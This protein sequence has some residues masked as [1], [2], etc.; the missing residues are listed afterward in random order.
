M[1][2]N[3][4]QL[5]GQEHISMKKTRNLID[6]LLVCGV[7][8]AMTSTLSAQTTGEQVAKVVRVQGA[9]RCQ[10]PGGTWQEL[11]S[12]TVI[13]AGSVIQSG[14]DGGSY[15]DVALGSGVGGLSRSGTADFKKAANIFSHYTVQTRQTVIHLYANTVLGL[16]RLTATDTGAGT[17]T[18]TELDLRKGRILGNVKKPAAGSD[19]RIRC[20]RGAASVHGG[21]FEMTVEE[22]KAVKQG[23]TAP[24]EQVHVTF[25]MA[26]G[27]GSFSLSGTGAVMQDVQAGQSFDS[28]AISAGNPAG[29]TPMPPAQ[30]GALTVAGDEIGGPVGVTERAALGSGLGIGSGVGGGMG[31]IFVPQA[32]SP[33]HGTTTGGG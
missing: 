7:A 29:L 9:A 19:F 10:A 24:G 1:N 25:A 33:T 4:L 18:Q 26:T 16:D 3:R 12:G 32:V 23:E 17:V 15:V 6:S 8:L 20:P 13:R 31:I 27:S 21:I 22:F 2:V 5:I 14:L 11:R 28:G 30:S